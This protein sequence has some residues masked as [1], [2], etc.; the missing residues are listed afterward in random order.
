MAIERLVHYAG[1]AD[2]VQQIFSS[3]NPVASSHFNFSMLEATGVVAILAPEEHSLIGLVSV[4]APVIAGGNTCVILAS[5]SRP[6][7]AITL[8]EVLHAS[9]V[10]GG[11]VNIL[12]GRHAELAPT[13][14]GH[15]DVDS[16]W[17]FSSADLSAEIERGAAGNL[18]RTWVNHGTARD[19]F[20]AEG[21][22]RAFL[23][24]ATEVKT[25]WVPYGA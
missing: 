4:M 17:S 6:L 16:V 7:C 21:A 19:W 20:G 12:T 11:V 25:V 1:W 8:A 2:K 15:L 3:V 5:E 18:K 9:D 14:A 24:A 10:P 22:G 23:D 13:L